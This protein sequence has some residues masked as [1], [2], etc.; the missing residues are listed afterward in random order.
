MLLPHNQLR[1][2]LCSK[3]LI[4]Q[5]KIYNIVNDMANVLPGMDT[6]EYDKDTNYVFVKDNFFTIPKT[7]GEDGLW[8]KGVA[9]IEMQGIRRGG[10]QR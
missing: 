3:W 9:C 8:G 4:E 7:I 2:P 5:R 6:C 10:H 1:V